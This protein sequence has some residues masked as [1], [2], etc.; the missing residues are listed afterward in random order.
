MTLDLDAAREAFA[1]SSD[2]TV[3]IEEEFQILDPA[4]LD[5]V[6]RYEELH[7]AAQDDPVLV[8]AVAGELIQSE[9]EIRSGRGEDLRAAVAQ[10]REARRALFGLA[11]ARGVALGATG[12]H[13]FA[14]YRDQL[15][16]QTEHY[17]RVVEGLQWVARRNNTFSLHVH[18]G[19]RDADRAVRICDRLRPVLPLLLAVSANST[20]LDA[21]DSG[22]HSARSQS[23]TKVFPRCG[24][25]DAYGSWAAYAD[26]IDLLRAT[27]SIVEYTQVWWSV[28]PHFS[29]GTVEVRICDAQSTAQES[30]GLAALITACVLQAGRDL[31]DGCPSPTRRGAWSRRTSGAPS[32]SARTAASSTSTAWR[33]T[34]RRR[35]GPAARLDGA[36]PRRLRARRAGPPG[37]QR[38]PA[39]AAGTRHGR[40]SARGSRGGRAGDTGHVPPPPGGH[41]MS[42]QD[43]GREPTEEELREAYEAQLKQLRVED[44]VL[45]TVVSLLNL[46]GRRAGLAPGTE[47][48]RDLGQVRMA[49]E[50]ARDMLVLIED[51]L[52]PDARQ[53]HDA[54][55]QLQLAYVRLGGQAAPAGA[56]GGGA[57]GGAGGGGPAG[58]GGRPAGAAA[59]PPSPRPGPSRARRRPAASGFRASRRGGRRPA[60]RR[61]AGA[62]RQRVPPSAW[63]GCLNP[64]RPAGIRFPASVSDP[65]GA[66][67][68]FRRTSP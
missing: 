6:P 60:S 17:R 42:Q 25:P 63:I 20:G 22:L 64:G 45:Q 26:Y 36:R 37:P 10:Q 4:S 50:G 11:E 12:T 15:N 13:P 57:P 5:L 24:I 53:L 38:R 55:A 35:R 1:A 30:E 27:N 19:I 47:D 33:S 44:V 65:R 62:V 21:R 54:L 29:F 8:T 40:G 16:I 31:D 41:G 51:Q 68:L 23:F 67:D 66:L 61:G 49:I 46:G 32:A 48:E 58:G 7:A 59:R 2:G 34:P 39:P 9:I 3:G 52:G 18:V 28:R 14:D 43:P 56:A